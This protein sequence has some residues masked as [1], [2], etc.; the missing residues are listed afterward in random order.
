MK[1]AYIE[2]GFSL[3]LFFTVSSY[4]IVAYII[5]LWD[6]GIESTKHVIQME[7]IWL[8]CFDRVELMVGIAARPHFTS[9]L[10]IRKF[11]STE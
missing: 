2:T 9:H 5:S 1:I 11:P 4:S 6:E 3:S 8:G 10:G 7:S